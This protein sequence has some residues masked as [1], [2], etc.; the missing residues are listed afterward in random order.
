MSSNLPKNELE[1]L[2]FWPSL[3]WQNFL[4]RFL[5]ELKPP[6]FS[7]EIIWPLIK[8]F[9]DLQIEK[10][11]KYVY[12]ISC[13]SYVEPKKPLPRCDCA[14]F[15]PFTMARLSAMHANWGEI[16]SN[17]LILIL[18]HLG[19]HKIFTEKIDRGVL[20]W[21]RTGER[22]IERLGIQTSSS[23]VKIW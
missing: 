12:G 20:N 16:F 8:I 11:W 17:F 2:K 3:L 6:K 21:L 23:F 18:V 19:F 7:S 5:K 22:I 10:Q 15:F 13:T 14:E 9:L 1:D 4:V